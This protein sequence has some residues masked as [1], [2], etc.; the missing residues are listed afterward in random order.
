MQPASLCVAINRIRAAFSLAKTASSLSVSASA[1]RRRFGRLRAAPI[2]TIVSSM[3]RS[4]SAIRREYGIDPSTESLGPGR[5][6]YA[7]HGG[8]RYTLGTDADAAPRAFPVRWRARSA[9][10]LRVIDL[11]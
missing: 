9:R 7:K 8:R 11:E 1:R 3:A 2:E 10:I 5:R 6:P 4:I